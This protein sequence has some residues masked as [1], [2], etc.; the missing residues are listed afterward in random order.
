MAMDKREHPRVVIKEM[1]ADIS[2]GKGFF[3]G[4]VHD[5]SR[6]GL[7]LYDVP[8]KIDAQSG[9][10]TVIVAGQRDHF[11]LQIKPCWEKT[12][13]LEKIIGG[14]IEEGSF[15]WSEFVMRLEPGNDNIWE[16]S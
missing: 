4:M 13:G 6:F 1:A 15:A 2:D 16:H 10:L 3:S 9:F 7:S 8:R 11:R 14:R 12:A 5:I